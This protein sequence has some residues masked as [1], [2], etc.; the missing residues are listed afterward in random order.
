MESGEVSRC[1]RRTRLGGCFNKETHTH[2]HKTK[3][4][5]TLQDGPLLVIHRVM[6]LRSRLISSL[7]P[8]YKAIYK[9]YNITCND[10]RGPPCILENGIVL[11]PISNCRLCR[12][13]FLP[14]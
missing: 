14:W 8:S 12:M 11:C 10:R 4:L 13:Y 9:G 7:L 6:I 3:N 5:P 1:Y 2:T